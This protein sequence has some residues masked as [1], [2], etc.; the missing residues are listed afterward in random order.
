MRVP[1]GD[2]LDVSPAQLGVGLQHQRHH[3]SRHG[4]AGTG[5]GVAGGAAVVK[6]SRDHFPLP[7]RPGA[8]GGGHGGAAGLA[9][10]GDQTVLRG[11]GHRQ[12]PD[13]VGVAVTV[14]VIVI[15][16][17]VATGPHED[18]SLPLPSVDFAKN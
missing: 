1:D 4:G 7:A 5:P 11:A 14:T 6:I 8:V 15:S 18:T 12:G 17:S 16:P 3:S 9:V 2:V 10:P 13:G